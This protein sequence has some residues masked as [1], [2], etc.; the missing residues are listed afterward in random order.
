MV[1]YDFLLHG[2]LHG[3]FLYLVSAPPEKRV[4]SF[5]TWRSQSSFGVKLYCERRVGLYARYIDV[6]IS[7]SRN[8]PLKIFNSSDVSWYFFYHFMEM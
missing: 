7:K 6:S 2:A 5:Q 3:Y 8:I 1:S 4:G